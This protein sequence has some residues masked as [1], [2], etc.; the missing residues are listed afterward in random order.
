MS[1]YQSRSEV[2]FDR[3]DDRRSRYGDPRDASIN[4]RTGSG[5]PPTREREKDTFTF[6]E[7][8]DRKG[9]AF[10]RDDYGQTTAGAMVLRARDREDVTYAPPRRR[11][12]PTPEKKEREEIII[13]R[14]ERSESRPPAP[15]AR[16][17]EVSREREEIIIRRDE[18]SD[19]RSSAPRP[20]PRE[21][22]RDR[23]EI[24][25][26]RDERSESRPPAPRYRERERSREREEI[27]IR[28]DE[29]DHHDYAPPRR[30]PTA[31]VRGER[32]RE[33]IIIRRDER[34]SRSRFDD[35]VVSHR[36]YR[37]PPPPSRNE[38]DREEIIIRREETD[39]HSRAPPSRS[40]Y[41]DNMALTRPISHERSRGRSHSSASED[42]I[43][44]RRDRDEGRGR[45]ASR[46]EII[47]RRTSHSRSPSPS[48]SVSTR[49]P[50]VPEPTPQP[51]PIVYAPQI[52]QEVITHHR[53]IDHGYEVRQPVYA[54][55]RPPSPPSPPPPPPPA[56]VRE[57]SEERIEIRRSETRNGK[58]E[59]EDIVISRNERSQSVGPPTRRQEREDYREEI[60]YSSSRRA[61]WEDRNIAEEAEYYNDRAL[62]RGYP[63]EA[64][65]GATRDWGLVDIP[66]GTKRVRMDGA[67]GGAQELSWKRY[68]GDRRAKFY[69]DGDY[70][71]G[72]TT[73]PGRPA[74]RPI[75]AP[76][77]EPEPPT[78]GPRYGA[79]K[80]P[81]DGL[82]TEVTK[83]LVV[84]EAIKEMG[85]EYEE[86]DEYYYIFKYMQYADVARLVG[87]SED[88]KRDRHKRI[89]E[90]RWENSAAP[91]PAIEPSSPRA[92]L[93]IEG[94]PARERSR[95]DWNREDERY[96]EREVVYRGGR[97]PPPVGWRR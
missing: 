29:H 58:R 20:R 59:E 65:R 77:P 22:S 54:P 81:R 93:A 86:T 87:L 26:R 46:Q 11:R 45:D 38:V 63:G 70:D 50:P 4:F 52:H 27:I 49:A 30:A 83:D 19:A 6:K 1:R 71:E 42:E 25:I 8:Y 78:I 41:E 74:P 18:Q 15:R 75:R 91:R 28:R 94:P 96:V 17:R 33:E 88:I 31:P 3:Y 55:P 90:I 73:D 5:A 85:Y 72:Y 51:P 36:S 57:R 37:P 79:R 16:P 47:I 67:G 44:I 92:P 64:Y 24:I 34:D 56:P 2:D 61:G 76:E 62:S 23:E 53:H 97:P 21:V 14:D 13:R 66:P 68:D 40:R 82:W 95:D 7:E 84:K 35:D 39:S 9:P 60:D 32:E 12:S 69:P 48:M 89:N 10:L 43:I 80:D